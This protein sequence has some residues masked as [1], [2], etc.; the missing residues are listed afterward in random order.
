MRLQP[1]AY[2]HHLHHPSRHRP[3]HHVLRYRESGRVVGRW[4][5]VEDDVPQ[6]GGERGRL[7]RVLVEIRGALTVLIV[8]LR[9]LLK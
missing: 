1:A 5:F 8:C 7:L 2:H 6:V 3:T 9:L 4:V